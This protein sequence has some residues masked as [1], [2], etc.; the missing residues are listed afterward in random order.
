MNEKEE[1]FIIIKNSIGSI[2]IKFFDYFLSFITGPILLTCLGDSKY[3]VYASTLSI[4]SWMYYFDFG[5]GSGMRNKVT[6]SVSNNNMDVAQSNVSTA[7]VLV[8]GISAV[9]LT[10]IVILLRFID[11]EN[12]LNAPV[13]NENLNY[14]MLIAFVL[15]GFNFIFSLSLN[16]LYAIKKTALVNLFGILSKA[17]ML[18]LL[19][20]FRNW[21]INKI[22]WI[23]VVEGLSQLAKNILATVYI[24]KTTPKL[25]YSRD[26]VEFSYSKGILHFGVQI[27]IMQISALVLN[28]TD[29]LIIMKFFTPSDVT[30]YSFCHKYFSII[31]AFFV[32]ATGPLWTAYTTAYVN[33]N[34]SYIKKTLNRALK[35]YALTVAGII[36]ALIIFKPFMRIYLK[37][38][39]NYQTGLPFLMAIYFAILIFS[40]NFSAFVHGISKVKYT[41]IACLI[42][43]FVNIPVSIILAVSF[44]LGINGV[45]LGSIICLIIT[46]VTYIYTTITEIKKLEEN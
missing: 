14:I 16:V 31:N 7:Y 18:V 23:V 43:A 10:V 30:P 35:F 5:I 20:I 36:F 40:H 28:S 3:G 32:A 17:I 33:K 8:S 12:L 22:I 42:S 38:D 26:H 13:E 9:I 34:V 46:T 27:F 19:I 45:L 21:G 4:I 1:N 11:T 6:E 2:I 15:T 25:S 37:R 29:N 24:R 44:N 39:L 41:T